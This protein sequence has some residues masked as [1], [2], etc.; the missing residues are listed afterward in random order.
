MSET[1]L[2]VCGHPKSEHSGSGCNF[3]WD[4]RAEYAGCPCVEYRDVLDW[5]DEAGNWWCDKPDW[6][7][8]SFPFVIRAG[9]VESLVV[10]F[11]G[12]HWHQDEWVACFGPARFVKLQEQNPFI[13]QAKGQA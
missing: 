3:D 8:E 12:E 2:C 10:E 4:S 1:K 11:R 5:P 13:E 6:I 7:V 9:I